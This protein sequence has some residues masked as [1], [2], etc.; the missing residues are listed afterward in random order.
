MLAS[1]RR[2]PEDL[3]FVGIRLES[4]RFHPVR[5]FVDAIG[6]ARRKRDHVSRPARAVYLGVVGLFCRRRFLGS[7][8]DFLAVP[9]ELRKSCRARLQRYKCYRLAR[10]RLRASVVSMGTRSPFTNY[11]VRCSAVVKTIKACSKCM[12]N[13]IMR[14]L[15]SIFLLTLKFEMQELRTID[16]FT[17]LKLS[18]AK[19]SA[20]I[21]NALP[22]PSASTYDTVIEQ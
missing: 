13:S 16:G 6:K 2:T 8:T 4:V 20:A 17:L 11:N 15:I 18:I 10:P 9:S 1:I 21:G 12:L 7:V 14:S 5:C 3:G 19:F 22:A